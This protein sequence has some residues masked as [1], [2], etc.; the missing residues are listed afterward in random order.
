MTAFGV[1]REAA[2][3]D[4]GAA[5]SDK[6]LLT[7]AGRVIHWIPA[8][9]I[10]FYT[11]SITA[12]VDDPKEDP[13]WW[14]VALGGAVAVILVIIG[15]A[16]KGLGGVKKWK[17]LVNIVLVVVAFV[18]WSPTVPN[19][20]WQDINVVA[21]HPV[22]TVIICAAAGLIFAAISDLIRDWVEGT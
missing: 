2:V 5:G 18:I 11:A 7:F 15:R 19:S 8:D 17:L 12:L 6:A 22:R 4:L 3:S 14:L 10:A 21:E 20:G 13:H 1:G 16:S 9:A